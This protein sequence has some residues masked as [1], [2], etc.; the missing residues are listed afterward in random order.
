MDPVVLFTSTEGSLAPKQF[1]LGLLAVYAA[2]IVSQ[3]LLT[4]TV[5]ARSGL[6]PFVFVQA[7]LLWSWTVLHIKRLRDAGRGPAGAFGVAALYA[8]S[9]GLLLLILSIFI[10]G[11]DAV[12]PGGEPAANAALGLMLLLV[13]LAF[14]FSPD[15]GAFT[16][17]LKCLVLIACLPV[18]ISLVFSLYT[19]LRR[20]VAPAATP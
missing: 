5:T 13:I 16:M 6:W 7:A 10:K 12:P 4:G 20:R 19:G 11:G 14:L 18:M 3:A 1:A 8:L 17:I 9:L 15:L 2:S